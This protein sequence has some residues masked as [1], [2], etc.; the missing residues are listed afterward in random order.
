MQ[1]V[2]I[3]QEQHPDRARLFM[4][5]KQMGWPVLVDSMNQLDVAVVPITLLIDAE[6]IVRQRVRGRSDPGEV[7]EKFLAGLP[8]EAEQDGPTRR[9]VVRAYQRPAPKAFAEAREKLSE[10]AAA[11]WREY[12]EVLTRW[13]RSAAE[14]DAAIDA[15]HTAV[16]LDQ[17]DARAQFRLGVA[18]R[19]RYDS[20]AGVAEDFTSA[21]EAWTAARALD[22]NNYIW[23]RRLQ[24]YG[25]RLAKPYPFYDWLGEARQ[26]VT[27]RGETPS[28]V[29]VEPRG[30]E[31]TAPLKDFQAAASS[32]NEPDPDG[33]I[34]RD[35]SKFVKVETL[36]VPLEIEAGESTRVHLEFRPNTRTDAHWNNEA[37]GMVVWFD[38]PEG[39]QVDRRQERLEL[40]P[41]A[42]SDEI[43]RIEFEVKSPEGARSAT[44]D[45][46]A[47]YYVCEGIN[48]QCLYRRQDIVVPLNVT[49]SERVPAV[50]SGE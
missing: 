8:Q 34:D 44:L 14:L 33:R 45:A 41:A 42:T 49:P 47:L 11:G 2:G 30:A 27:A 29:T 17:R 22:P 39:W 32:M 5:W 12:A 23:M 24:Q 15:F 37:A 20:P 21:V 38:P 36:T 50:P 3:I 16:R 18:F 35:P 31:L 9:Q 7:V 28:S 19:M 10:T 26:A 46:Y 13:S 4:Q 6:G 40:P 1:V 25:P 43:R 48:G